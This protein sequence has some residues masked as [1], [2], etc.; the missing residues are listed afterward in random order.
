MKAYALRLP[1]DLHA[2]LV[3]MAAMSKRSLNSEI[4][5][6]LEASTVNGVTFTTDPGP[7]PDPAVRGM[8]PGPGGAEGADGKA[9]PSPPRAKKPQKARPARMEMCEHRRPAGAFC[10]KCDV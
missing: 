9:V 5:Y 3:D 4:I 6:R 1:E 8:T 2:H 7:E 10:P